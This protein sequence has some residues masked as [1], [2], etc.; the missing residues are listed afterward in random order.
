M[1]TTCD[2]RKRTTWKK[3]KDKSVFNIRLEMLFRLLQGAR[4]DPQREI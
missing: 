2:L 1:Q 3:L 4:D